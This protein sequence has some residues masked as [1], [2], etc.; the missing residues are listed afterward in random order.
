MHHI[1]V[2]FVTTVI[3]TVPA[4]AANVSQFGT[5]DE[6]VAMVKGVQEKFKRD[7][8]QATFATVTAKAKLFHD[9]DLYPFIY[10]LNGVNVAHGARPELVGK[11]LIDFKD[12]NGKFLIREMIALAN[13]PGSGWVNYRWTNPTTNEVEDKS[14][15]VEKMGQYFVGVGVYKPEQANENTVGTVLNDGENL[16]IIPVVG[17]G[18]PQNI[19]DV[20]TLK[21]ID[22]GLTQTSILNNFRRSNELLGIKDDK[23][24][25][26]AKLFNEEFHL[27]ARTDIASVEQLRGQKVNLDEK[28]SGTNYSMRD[29][30]KRLDIGVEEVNMTQAEAFE[31]LK[32]GEIAASVLIAGKPTRSM[33]TLKLADG[34]H[35][36][37]IPYSKALGDDYL[38]AAL[39][40]EDYPAMISPGQSIDTVA[41]GAVLVAYNW[42]K[43]TD[44][45]RRV[46]R[47]VNAFF[48]R[49]AE[50]HKPPR[51]VKWREVNLNS[52]LAGWNRLEAA[53]AWL[54]IQFNNATADERTRFNTFLKSQRVSGLGPASE[55]SEQSELLFQEFLKWKRA[56]ESNSYV[57]DAILAAR[58]TGGIS[59][60]FP[61]DQRRF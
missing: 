44:R 42:P 11:D 23:V 53:Q 25:Y 21:G 31:K 60:A 7:G 57:I 47:F 41:V 28:G 51:H 10:D 30:I 16:R 2:A 38:P 1:L 27:V 29:V 43:N 61:D 50:F 39:T 22:I 4:L 33:T 59:V 20:R 13:G 48:P 35:F 54:N 49:I 32:S 40:H 36:L 12:Q 56:R 3:L 9:R 46:E 55:S 6:A 5:R 14:A 17:I 18:G 52:N 37:P 26:I 15:Y 8:P 45:Y 58:Q 19:R 34:L 24:V